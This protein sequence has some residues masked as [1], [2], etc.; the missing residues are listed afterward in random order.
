MLDH[1]VTQLALIRSRRG[2]S[3]ELGAQLAMLLAPAQAADGCLHCA[4]RRDGEDADLWLVHALWTSRE[5]LMSHLRSPQAQVF[6]AIIDNCSV[7]EMEL[8]TLDGQHAVEDA[9]LHCAA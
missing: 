9:A 3:D 4:I 7:R 1:S 2:R 8:F 6:A 5:A